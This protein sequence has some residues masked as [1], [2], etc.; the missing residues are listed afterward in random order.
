MSGICPCTFGNSISQ[1]LNNLRDAKK[2]NC[3]EPEQSSPAAVLSRRVSHNNSIYHESPWLYQVTFRLEGGG[4]IELNTTE[5]TYGTLKEG[6][7][8]ELTWKEDRI[9]GF[10]AK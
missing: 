1:A 9:V 8:G 7:A 4:E 10:L 5:E 2:L 3:D 6:L